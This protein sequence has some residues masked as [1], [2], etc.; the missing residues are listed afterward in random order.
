MELGLGIFIIVVFC[1]MLKSGGK[2]VTRND[3]SGTNSGG[4]SGTSSGGGNSTSSSKDSTL[5]SVD[6]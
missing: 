5:P 6:K 1:L 2:N 3:G 4:G